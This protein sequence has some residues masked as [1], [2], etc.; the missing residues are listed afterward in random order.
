MIRWRLAYLIPDCKHFRQP[1]SNLAEESWPRGFLHE[2]SEHCTAGA[3]V[4]FF[5]FF[6]SPHL[7]RCILCSRGSS[8]NIFELCYRCN[9]WHIWIF[10][11]F[12]Y[13]SG[14]RGYMKSVVLDLLKRYLQVEMQFQQGNI[15]TPSGFMSPLLYCNCSS[16]MMEMLL[17]IFGP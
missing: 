15:S 14:I 10:F 3:E 7:V 16:V 5:F 12:R 17:F 11:L 8:S 13:R 4:F 9:C 2:H 1:C 6:F